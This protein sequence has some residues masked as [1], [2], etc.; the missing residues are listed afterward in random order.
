MEIHHHR[1]RHPPEPAGPASTLAGRKPC[2]TPSRMTP[3]ELTSAT[4]KCEGRWAG[5]GPSY[6]TSPTTSSTPSK[7][8]RADRAA[9][10]TRSHPGSPVA[11]VH[12]F[13]ERRGIVTG[14]E[15]DEFAVESGRYFL[16]RFGK[17]ELAVLGWPLHAAIRGGVAAGTAGCGNGRR[18]R[19]SSAGGSTTGSSIWWRR[20]RPRPDR[21]PAAPAR[22]PGRA[23]GAGSAAGYARLGYRFGGCDTVTLL[24]KKESC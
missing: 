9:R 16:E 23:T 6:E 7:A 12:S 13:V 19:S 10:V 3:D 5:S 22:P 20:R 4:T 17:L 24:A 21:S 18:S 11:L 15:R 1:P 8:P 2:P 14:H